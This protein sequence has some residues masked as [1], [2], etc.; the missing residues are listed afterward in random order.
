MEVVPGT[1]PPVR[2]PALQPCPDTTS[3]TANEYILEAK[4]QKGSIGYHV[5]SNAVK[6]LAIWRLIQG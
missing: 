2:L 4:P 1:M 3:W 6:P 5:H